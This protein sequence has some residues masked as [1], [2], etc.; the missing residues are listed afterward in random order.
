MLRPLV[1][2]TGL[3][4]TCGA[5]RRRGRRARTTARVQVLSNLVGN[6]V[7]FTPAPGAWSS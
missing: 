2:G 7:K 3:A 4:L 1:G 5:T 6:A